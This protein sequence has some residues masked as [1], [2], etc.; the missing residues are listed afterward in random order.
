MKLNVHLRASDGDPL[1]NPMCYCHLFEVLGYLAV[2][3]PNITYHVHILSQFVSAPTSVYYSHLLRVL[4]YL[5][6]TISHRLFFACSSSLRSMP[7][8]MLCEL[9]ILQTVDHFLLTM[10]FLVAHSLLG[11]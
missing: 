11:I 6:S 5:R 9:V 4:Q 3:R 7:T 10:C 1:S 8:L 2:T